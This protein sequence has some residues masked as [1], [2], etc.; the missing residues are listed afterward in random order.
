MPEWRKYVIPPD[1]ELGMPVFFAQI[2]ILPVVRQILVLT[3]DS[4]SGAASP[5]ALLI[6]HCRET[7]LVMLDDETSEQEIISWLKDRGILG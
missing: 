7:Y 4:V 2:T 1:L 3:P 5:L 6:S